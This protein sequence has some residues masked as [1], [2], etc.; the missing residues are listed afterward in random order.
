MTDT[1]ASSMSALYEKAWIKLY[2][3]KPA[4]TQ[5]V[6]IDNPNGREA[7]D[8][9]HEVAKLAEKWEYEKSQRDWDNNVPF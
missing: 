3:K 8:M 1:T 9:A 7:T 2:D 6:I 5:K 4:C